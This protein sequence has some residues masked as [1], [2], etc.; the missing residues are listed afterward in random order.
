VHPNKGIRLKT[1]SEFQDYYQLLGLSPHAS[2]DRIIENIRQSLRQWHPDVCANPL[3]HEMTVRILEAKEVLLDEETRRQYDSERVRRNQAN[4]RAN[5]QSSADP[6]FS[7]KW[8]Q[9]AQNVHAKARKEADFSIDELLVKVAQITATGAEYL[10]KGDEK[11]H[12][13]MEA[14]SG[15]LFWVGVASWGVVICLI[16]PGTSII[17]F[18]LFYWAFFPRPQRKFIGI[19]NLMKGMAITAMIVIPVVILI[20][21][22]IISNS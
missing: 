6:G 19:G 2:R 1:E 18:G 20:L 9:T 7:E 13:N 15:Q 8:S 22:M 16:V 12:G 4:N 3:A 10:W 5:S 17:T 14:T 21:G 11:F